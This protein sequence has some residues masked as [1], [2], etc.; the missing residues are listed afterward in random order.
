[1]A[2]LEEV[3]TLACGADFRFSEAVNTIVEPNVEYQEA[4][5]SNPFHSASVSLYTCHFYSAVVSSLGCRVYRT[6]DDRIGL[7]PQ[8]ALPGDHISFLFGVLSIKFIRQKG[9]IYNMVGSVC[10][11]C[12][13]EVDV[14]RWSQELSR[15]ENKVV[16]QQYIF[17]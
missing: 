2:C 13:D 3:P 16:P 6:S 17:C 8:N 5:F 12:K 9:Y 14:K 1:M 4:D 10:S 15:G 11:A 7:A